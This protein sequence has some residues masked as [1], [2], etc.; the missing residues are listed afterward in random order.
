MM[1]NEYEFTLT[2]ST[3]VVPGTNDFMKMVP[4]GWLGQTNLS[5]CYLRAISGTVRRR[6]INGLI[7][8]TKSWILNKASKYDGPQNVF[9]NTFLIPQT[10]RKIHHHCARRPCESLQRG[11]SYVKMKLN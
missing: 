10:Q 4:Q 9:L 1:F 7:F 11:S 8:L 2:T 3:R 6:D 5:Q